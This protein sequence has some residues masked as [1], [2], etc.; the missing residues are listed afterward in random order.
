MTRRDNVVQFQM[1]ERMEFVPSPEKRRRVDWPFI[2]ACMLFLI[3][4][5]AV[6]LLLP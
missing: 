5:A 4:L 3:A 2:G 1:R 6:C